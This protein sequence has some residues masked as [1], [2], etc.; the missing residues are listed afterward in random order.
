MTIIGFKQTTQK[1][2]TIAGSVAV[3]QH[4]RTAD[5]DGPNM[6]MRVH[7]AGNLDMQ[8]LRSHIMAVQL[9]D[10]VLHLVDRNDLVTVLR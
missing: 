9:N 7:P 4:F 3:G 8:I 1:S 5:Y 2:Y 10:G 6:F